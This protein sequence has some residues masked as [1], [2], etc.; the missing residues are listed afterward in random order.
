MKRMFVLFVGI[1]LSATAAPIHSGG[2]EFGRQNAAEGQAAYL[3]DRGIEA[4]NRRD[5]DEALTIF[6]QASAAGHVKA[7][8]YIGV[9]YLNGYGVRQNA[10]RA[11]AEFKKAADKGDITAQYWLAYCYEHGLGISKSI[12]EAVD[13]YQESARRGDHISA[14]AMTALGRLAESDDVKEALDWYKKSAA[15]GDKEAQAALRRLDIK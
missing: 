11:A 4:F 1:I 9:M 8:R 14:P 3:L 6:T 7:Q 13:W 2:G 5:Y 15:A 12:S 10:G